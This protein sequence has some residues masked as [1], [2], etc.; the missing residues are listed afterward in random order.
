MPKTVW[1]QWL[2]SGL[3]WLTGATDAPISTAPGLLAF[4]LTP[5]GDPLPVLYLSQYTEEISQ[6]IHRAK[7]GADWATATALARCMQSLP[8]DMPWKARGVRLVPVP[9]DPERLRTRGFH[10]PALLA[11]A[12]G[13]HWQ[14]AVSI[15]ALKKVHA[16]PEQA[17]RSRQ[18][19]HAMD[20]GVF[21]ATERTRRQ[22]PAA[23]LVD[24]VMTT[25]ATLR[26]AAQ[27]W[28]RHGGE[29]LGAVVLAYVPA[30]GGT[31]P[32]RSGREAGHEQA[33]S[34]ADQTRWHTGLWE[35]T[36]GIR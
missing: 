19:R 6:H 7:Y 3:R 10:L 5:A 35:R 34:K 22:G 32:E 28:Q 29:V 14:T 27:A 2:H 11:K 16:S 13:T 24:D 15:G 36:E 30:P 26:A 25:G 12:L 21:V 20:A 18:A 23:V 9:P 33:P 17:K 1:K 31:P 8:A 4:S